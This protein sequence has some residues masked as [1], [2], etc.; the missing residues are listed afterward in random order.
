M[1]EDQVFNVLCGLAVIGQPAK[2]SNLLRQRHRT[3]ETTSQ[4]LKWKIRGEGTLCQLWAPL[5]VVLAHDRFLRCG[6]VGS[7]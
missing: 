2:L 4:C 3:A 1:I 5:Q 6:N 7:Q